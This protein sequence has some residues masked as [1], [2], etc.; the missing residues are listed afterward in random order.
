MGDLSFSAVFGTKTSTSSRTSSLLEIYLQPIYPWGPCCKCGGNSNFH[1]FL[2]LSLRH[3]PGNCRL[4]S[5]GFSWRELLLEQH[6]PSDWHHYLH[7][8]AALH[9]RK[10]AHF[11][12]STGY[13][14][15]T[16]RCQ[17]R[18]RGAW[19]GRS[20]RGKKMLPPHLRRSLKVWPAQWRESGE[21][22]WMIDLMALNGFR[23][24]APKWIVRPG[25]PVQGNRHSQQ[26]GFP[27]AKHQQRP[28]NPAIPPFPQLEQGCMDLGQ[29]ISIQLQE[30]PVDMFPR[31]GQLINCQ[32]SLALSC[33]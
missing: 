23:S 32:G 13:M 4:S 29:S 10:W 8:Q 17:R 31:H 18:K 2:L 28:L 19:Q 11:G 33:H 5:A 26:C 3:H 15:L 7:V 27:K 20:R 22:V 1:L 14:R 16:W 9:C 12:R 21:R 30:P 25:I 24:R 6:A